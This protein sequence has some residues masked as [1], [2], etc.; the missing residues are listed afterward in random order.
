MIIELKLR[1]HILD[2]LV[3][4]KLLDQIEALDVD[5]FTKEV[6]IGPKRQDLSEAVFVIESD[7]EAK[8]AQALELAKKQGA[9]EV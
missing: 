3:L 6:K 4:S 5:C 8:I 1:G 2:S 7:D 9:T